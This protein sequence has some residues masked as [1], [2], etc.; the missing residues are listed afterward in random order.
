MVIYSDNYTGMQ[1]VLYKEGTR[2]KYVV[3]KETKTVGHYPETGSGLQ[4]AL[5]LARGA[6]PR[7]R[8]E[9]LATLLKDGLLE[10]DKESAQEYFDE[11]C[12]MTDTE[13]EWFG[14]GGVSYEEAV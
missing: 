12:E 10:D 1:I 3:F 11:V 4:Q 6:I 7:A 5:D 9:E 13:K 2:G 14:I 8:L